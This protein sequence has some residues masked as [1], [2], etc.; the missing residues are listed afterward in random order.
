MT[1]TF[2]AIEPRR[3]NSYFGFGHTNLCAQIIQCEEF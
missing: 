3:K 1:G 2:E